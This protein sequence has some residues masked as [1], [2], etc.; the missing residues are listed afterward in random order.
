M[1]R[2]ASDNNAPEFADDQ[3]PVQVGDQVNAAR[4]IAENTEA[5]E[6]IG[7]PVAA[8]D[9]DSDQKLTYTLEGVGADLFDIDRATGQIMTKAALDNSEEDANGTNKTV[10]VKATDPAGDSETVIV[11]ITVTDVN[12]PPSITG[13]AEKSFEE[14][15]G[16]IFSALDTYMA[17]D[18]EL[19]SLDPDPWS[20][21]G[22]DGSK[23]DISMD[24]ALTFKAKPD[25]EMPTDTNTDNV[26]EV[27]VRAADADGN[28]GTMDVKVS[29]TNEDESG[30]VTLSKTRPRVGIA[31]MASVTDPDGRISA[32][33][34]QWSISSGATKTAPG[35]IPG[36]T[37]DTYTPKMGDVNGTLTAT[38]RYFDGQNVPDADAGRKKTAMKLAD[39]VVAV[40]TRN[41]APVF[42]DQDSSTDGVQNES[43]TREVEENREPVAA[44][45]ALV[46][47]N[48]DVA[49]NVGS[50]I[51]ATDPDPNAEALI[52]TL[53]G[54][55]ADKFRVRSNG[56]IEVGAGTELDYETKTT[57]E[58]TVIAEDSFGES[59]SI[60]VTIMVTDMDE[61]PVISVGGL[62]VT[63]QSAIDYAE[64]GTG[65]VATY[66]AAG[67]DASSATWT[68]SGVDANDFRISTAGVLTF[69]TPPN[70]EAPADSKTD[71]V[72]Q[73]TVKAADGTNTATKAVAVTVTDVDDNQ[74]PS[75]PAETDTRS[76]VEG[77]AVGADIGA[78]VTAE[79]PD[80]GDALTYTLGGTDAASFNVVRT[81]GQLQTKAAL[82]YDTKNSYAVTVT[83]TDGENASASIDVTIT[84]TD[85]DEAQVITGDAAPNYAENGTGPVATYTATDPESATIT[86]SL[87][88]DD[89]ADFEIS[90]SGVLTFGSPPD[91]ENPADADRDN[92]YE[93][94]VKASAGTNEDT[95]DVTI[96][97]T[98]VDE[99]FEVSGTAAVDYAENGTAAVA[100]Y[101]ATDPE[102][103][104]ITWSLEGNDAADFEISAG[105]ML[106]FVSS[107][108]HENPADADPDNVYEVT[109]KASDGTNN[110]DTL[111][112]TITVTDVD[113]D[114]TPAD[115]L[116][117]KYDA[118][119][120]G[121]IERAE[122]FAAIDDYL[123]G[124][125]GAPTRADVFKLIELY[126][127]D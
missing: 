50:V 40:D 34:W 101:S 65:M 77:A 94:T 86:W 112:V 104:T 15:K 127:G 95:L 99:G 105:G 56:Q 3:D 123:D 47:G 80:V 110:E 4:E 42:D 39:K 66:S 71:N 37:S 25:Y 61:A 19:V 102:S 41:R 62:V 109:V 81:S 45:D 20:V 69:R 89:A 115:P 118:D 87:E 107:P 28:I 63:G 6:N 126:L 23:F 48:E 35:S 92:V 55:N 24:G 117:D 113:E 38:A 17:T 85:V 64:N 57:Y 120:N 103:A 91:H 18:P 78:P 60:M 13:A 98:N 97:V 43:T 27:T 68:L 108:D 2:T 83:A 46:N 58:V 67:P 72:Y 8:T 54:A 116:V 82:D 49:D 5:G 16:D 44:D 11:D 52:Y 36:A 93:V 7:A 74:P 1:L 100:T 29:V 31:V 32:L 30:V 73:V 22:A 12:E 59:A 106:T 70:Y 26:Y 79:D 119:G 10:T 84:V 14:V 53:G 76:V 125:A 88:G 111:D 90:A 33:T 75:F 21:A 51:A 96:T 124:D 122:V 114:V 9:A 121:E